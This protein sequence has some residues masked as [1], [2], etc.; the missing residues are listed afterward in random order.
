MNAYRRRQPITKVAAALVALAACDGSNNSPTQPQLPRVSAVTANYHLTIV[1]DS[2]K[3]PEEV[4]VLADGVEI[5]SGPVMG[6]GYSG[7]YYDDPWFVSGDLGALALAVGRHTLSIR[8]AR[9]AVS[10][11]TYHVGGR[12]EAVHKVH[13]ISVDSQGASWSE[14]VTLVPGETWTGDFEIREW[15]S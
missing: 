10:P 2:G 13:G 8:V 6:S 11:T 12:V 4:Q 3:P 9:Q 5:Y 7:Y 14:T 15:R 1:S